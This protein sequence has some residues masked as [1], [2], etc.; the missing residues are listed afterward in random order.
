M[1]QPDFLTELF[2]LAKKDGLTTLVDSNGTVPF[3]DYPE[4]ME[5]MDGVMLDIKAFDSEEHRKVTGAPNDTVLENAVYL[6]EAAKLYEV[7][8]VIVP[9]LYDTEQ[10]VRKMG[11]FLAPCLA[12][13]RFRIKVIAYRP[14]GVRGEY[15]HYQVPTLTY[16]N[17]L[18]DILKNYGF[19]DIVII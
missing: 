1:L 18:A 16:L 4:L 7:R 13:H 3:K 10:S 9:D 11:E 2:K 12:V 14:M 5:V 17:H 15:A 6:A 19:D 8:A